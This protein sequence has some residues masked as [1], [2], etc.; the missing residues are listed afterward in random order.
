MT[1]CEIILK[2]QGPLMSSELSS[3]LVSQFGIVK[4]TASQAI[5]RDTSIIKILR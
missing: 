4:N 5:T 1:N 3:L 2:Q